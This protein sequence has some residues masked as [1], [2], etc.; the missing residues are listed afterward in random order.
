MMKESKVRDQGDDRLWTSNAT[1]VA[2]LF[3]IKVI[4]LLKIMQIYNEPLLSGQPPLSGNFNYQLYFQYLQ[5]TWVNSIHWRV[6]RD[7]F[8]KQDAVL[9][10][11]NIYFL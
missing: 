3:Q 11:K 2:C 4:L 5:I 1:L 7:K 8:G 10:T 9:K 6:F